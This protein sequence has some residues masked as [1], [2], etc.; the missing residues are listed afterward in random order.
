EP[1]RV[2]ATR[3]P[4]PTVSPLQADALLKSGLATVYDVE[5]RS[6]FEKRHIADAL[7]AVPDRLEGFVADLVPAQVVVIT[8]SDG[9][10]ARTVAAELAAR[11]GR[12]VRALAG[13][14]SA[15]VAAGLATRSGAD[16]VL[17]GDDDHWYSPYQHADIALRNAGF[18][19]YLDWEIGLVA[20]LQREGDIGIRL[21]EG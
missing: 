9:V 7:F 5:R 13:G 10:L 4:A 21:I 15:W 3:P 2:L 8:S 18:Q 16:G 11:S 12:D 6:A 1:L 20:Q 14:T 19:A 17:T